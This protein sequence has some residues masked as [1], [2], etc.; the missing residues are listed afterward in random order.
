MTRN[1][2]LHSGP[3]AAAGDA[4]ASEPLARTPLRRVRPELLENIY[5]DF[6]QVIERQIAETA[7]ESYPAAEYR[8]FFEYLLATVDAGKYRRIQQHFLD[9]S[10]VD[11]NSDVVK[12]L[13]PV[14]WFQSKVRLC[15]TLGLDKPPLQRILE[16]A[17]PGQVQQFHQPLEQSVHHR[18]L[19]AGRPALPLHAGKVGVHRPW[20]GHRPRRRLRTLGGVSRRGEPAGSG[21]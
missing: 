10:I 17:R 5:A 12:Y 13:D 18:W 19:Q 14:T 4:A 9:P 20:D 6:R 16:I 2:A 8:R 3:K 11:P 7:P 21:L 1:M 15:L